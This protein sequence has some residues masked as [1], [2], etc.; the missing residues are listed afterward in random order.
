MNLIAIGMLVIV[1]ISVVGF[2]LNTLKEGLD[3]NPRPPSNIP[4]KTIKLS[5]SIPYGYY[6]VSTYSSSN[7]QIIAQ[8]PYGYMVNDSGKLVP[9]T[10]VAAYDA[11]HPFISSSSHSSSSGHSSSSSH[12]PPGRYDID[13]V[14]VQYH[15]TTSSLTA[16][17]SESLEQ[18]GT[19]VIG[20]SGNKILIPWSDVTTESTYYQP[21]SYPYGPSNYVPNYED[22]VYLSQTTGQSQNGAYKDA[23]SIASGF[24][25]QNAKDSISVEQKCNALDAN[26]CA[27]TNCC[28]SLGGQKCVAGTEFGPTMHSNYSDIYVTNKDYYYYQ[29]KCYGNCNK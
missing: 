14:G 24:C 4:Q 21:G 10:K 27:S 13:N 23:G 17:A 1:L 2:N 15:A 18:T 11:A 22:S 25:A 16:S 5:S 12:S 29:G 6:Q 20:P 28:V 9:K 7:T 3:V 8:V 26:T 19:W